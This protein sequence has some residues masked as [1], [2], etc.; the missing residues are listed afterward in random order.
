IAHMPFELAIGDA[1]AESFEGDA[2]RKT[3]HAR[4]EQVRD[5]RQVGR[6]DIRRNA[7]RIMREPGT[8]LAAVAVGPAVHP[9]PPR[10]AARVRR[11]AA[12][13][14]TYGGAERLSTPAPRR[15]RAALFRLLEV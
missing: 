4:L 11:Q 7:G 9:S 1:L 10:R 15:R 8:G 13:F 5:G 14:R 6:V 3:R 2:V 12:G